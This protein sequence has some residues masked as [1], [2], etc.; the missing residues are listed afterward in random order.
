MLKVSEGQFKALE[1]ACDAIVASFPSETDPEYW[2]SKASDLNVASE[3]L[4]VIGSLTAEEQKEFL[5]LLDLLEMRI[6]GLI[7]AGKWTRFR[8]LPF[9]KQQKVLKKWLGSRFN[10]LRKAFQSIK[11]LSAF[12][13]YGSSDD[14]GNPTWKALGYPGPLESDSDRIE[15]GPLPNI[16]PLTPQM[17][18]TLDCDVV[19]VGSGAGGGLIA[20]MLAEAGHQVLVVEKGPFV[21]GKGWNQRETE[22]IRK[23]YDQQGAFVT[24]DGGVTIFA[25]SCLGGGTS[26][27]W[28][29][30]FPTPDYVLD[31]WANEHGFTA[32]NSPE[33]AAAL[34]AAMDSISANTDN[35][36]HN[37]QNQALWRGSEALGQKI[38]VIHRNVEGCKEADNGRAC[39]FCGMGC[40]RGNKRGTLRTWLQRAADKEA[41]FL[42]DTT[43]TRVLKQGDQATGIEAVTRNAVGKP[44]T[45]TVRAK[46]VVVAA[47]SVQTPALLMRSGLSHPQLGRNL[48]FHPTVG[49]TGIYDEVMEPWYGVMMSAVNKEGIRT[50]GN[51]GYWIETPPLHTGVAA[52]A[53]PWISARQHKEDLLRAPHMASFIVLTR[54]K[55]GGRVTVDK[56]GQARVDYQV[57]AED[58]SVM[59]QGMKAAWELHRAAGAREVVF[60]HSSHKTIDASVSEAEANRFISGMPGWGWSANQFNLFTAHQM[61]TCAMGGNPN[62]HPVDP[63]G[64]W[65][66]MKGL[67]IADGSL[68]PTCAGINPMVSIMGLAHWIGQGME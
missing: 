66:G 15:P 2:A 11:R 38:G 63:S 6:T 16:R 35:S 27:N 31:E 26:I 68:M 42:V 28:T 7:W 19:V 30:S 1:S 36:P 47:G 25:G 56:Q 45:I 33:Y 52:L 51:F 62:R 41:Q 65:R 29:G 12:L 44:I 59:L 60:P 55:F 5:Q 43:V 8:D 67:Y 3:I 40:R 23:T 17:D 9:E 64:A 18:M 37:P 10:L 61:G 49:V 4:T 32:A 24:K 13:H 58:R 22:M 21:S 48:F 57:H 46:R 34:Q 53:S 54:D 50:N 20:G 14:D 39:G